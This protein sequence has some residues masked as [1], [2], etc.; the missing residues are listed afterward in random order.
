MPVTMKS[1][2]AYKLSLVM[3]NIIL[4]ILLIQLTGL[5]LVGQ[6]T[7]KEKSSPDLTEQ[8]ILQLEKEYFNAKLQNNVKFMEDFLA[9]DF[10]STNQ[11]GHVRNKAQSI[12]FF[13]GFKP[14][15][16]TVD[17]ISVKLENDKAAVAEGHQTENGEKFSFTHKLVNQNGNWRIVSATQE[18]PE[19]QG[20]HG[21]GYYKISGSIKGA[22]GVAVSL[23]RLVGNQQ[24][25]INSAIIRNGRF[26]MEG[27]AIEYPDMVILTTPGKPRRTSFF[28]ENTDISLSGHI[29]SLDKAK[30]S[31]SETHDEY[32]A[33]Q[34]NINKFSE[35]IVS[36]AKEYETAMNQKDTVKIAMFTREFADFREKAMGAHKDFIKNNPGSFATPVILNSIARDLTT[37]ETDAIIKSL[38]PP[39]A[40]TWTIL[41]IKE[42]NESLKLVDIGK[43]APD[44]TMNDISGKPVSLSSK[45]GT[46]L[47][48][49]DFWAGW[50]AP[51]RKENPNVV[52]VYNMFKDQGFDVLGVSLDRTRNVWTNAVEADGLPWTQVSDLQYWNTDAARLYS[53]SAIPANFLIDRDGII[54][55]KNLRGEELMKA[56]KE[57][58]G[59][60]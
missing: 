12:A 5:N 10:I 3:R 9:D 7:K 39:V 49:I 51:C 59:E 54:I 41:N 52:K 60:L 40:K 1:L 42:K 17:E 11:F 16:F 53:V 6:T 56:V 47:L 45:I 24:V 46:K 25:N 33:H 29:D 14:K 36:M 2:I 34:A 20:L 48:L 37:Y 18:F 32:L 43:R 4:I 28:L 21:K 44:F 38:D 35:K 27:D 50:C 55:A 23:M 31:G 30:V 57:R 8:K 26:T 13:K 15:S 19:F 58:M 22:E